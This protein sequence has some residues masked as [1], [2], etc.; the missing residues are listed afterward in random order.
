MLVRE[1]NHREQARE[2]ERNK[3]I[4]SLGRGKA[5]TRLIVRELTVKPLEAKRINLAAS[6]FKETGESG[7]FKMKN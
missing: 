6:E 2:Q 1:A 7:Q 3:F 5:A 4:Y